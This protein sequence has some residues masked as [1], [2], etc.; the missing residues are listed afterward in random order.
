MQQY[1]LHRMFHPRS[2]RC[3]DV[4]VDHGCMGE[5]AMLRGIEDMPAV[6]DTLVGA[7]PD[8]VQLT[9]GQAP[10]LQSRPGRDKPA[11]VLRIDTSNVYRPAPARELFSLVVDDAVDQAV[12][13]D[14]ACVV[15]NLL[16]VPDHPELLQDCLR[17][18]TRVQAACV[19]AGMPMMVEPLAFA[20]AT[21]GYDTVGDVDRI[22]GLVRQAVELGADVIK[23]D[24]T[25][26]L[27]TYD[28]V[29]QAAAPAPVLVRGGGRVS[30]AEVFARTRSLLDRGARGVVYGRN[31]F[32]H[33]S[34]GAMARA[35]M[36]LLH[37]DVP[38]ADAAAVL[39]QAPPA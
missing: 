32:G 34:P 13:L 27:T 24:P 10:L 36:A 26:D 37:D 18:V 31:V 5:A 17:N 3:L 8:A 9:V 39:A 29:V 30:D 25:D 4:A 20:A 35:L 38:A 33:P 21:G 11:L 22:V 6:I 15:L 12:R 23:A 7:T 1:R 16:D 14:A 28:R 2:G 19:R